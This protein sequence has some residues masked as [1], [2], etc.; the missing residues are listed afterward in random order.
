MY[1]Y[2]NF[3]GKKTAYRQFGAAKS[4]RKAIKF[5]NTPWSLKQKRKWHS[6]IDEKIK[7]Y[8]YNWIMHHPQVVQSPLVNDCLKVKIDGHS[9]PKMVPELL[10]HV[11]VRELHNN[12][13]SATMDGCLKEARD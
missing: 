3:R 9:E 7:K 13:V 4:K 1:V 10:F 5:G 8:L 6:N 2:Q 12:F 11:Y